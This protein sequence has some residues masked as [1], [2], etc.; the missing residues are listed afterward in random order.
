MKKNETWQKQ[1]SGWVLIESHSIRKSV[2]CAIVNN[3]NPDKRVE[4]TKHY[5]E[6][7]LKHCKDYV[8]GE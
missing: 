2:L 4:L 6:F 5:Q 3:K 7:L 8:I 1:K